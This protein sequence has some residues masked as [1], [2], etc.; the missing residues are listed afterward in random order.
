[1]PLT[2]AFRETVMTRVQNDPEFRAELI[3]EATIAF[4]DG[5]PRPGDPHLLHKTRNAASGD[6]SC[7]E[8][9]C[10]REI[11]IHRGIYM[12]VVYEHLRSLGCDD[13]VLISC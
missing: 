1:M 9:E 11:G 8:I 13:P 10:G 2:R 6:L 12:R 5:D 7:H 3:R 4:L